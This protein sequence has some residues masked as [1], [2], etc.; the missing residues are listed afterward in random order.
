M[1]RRRQPICQDSCVLRSFEP[2]I[3]ETAPLPGAVVERVHRDLT[4]VHHFLGDT[5]H[6]VR[7]IRSD[8]LPVTRVLDVGCGHGGVLEEVRQRLRVD[9]VGVDLHPPERSSVPIV[10]A[11]GVRDCL[12][13]ADVAYSICVAHHLTEGEVA[14]LICNVGRSC[15]RFILL[16][17]VRHW[18]P[19]ALFRAFVAPLLSHVAATDGIVS[20]RRAYTPEEFRAIAASTGVRFRHSV[21]PFYTRQILDIEY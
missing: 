3:L 12:P 14:A 8:P 11:D 7:A 5:R 2:E 15:R 4:K 6:V 18:L 20:V 13:K 10:R 19:L 21:A 16:D 9:V 17:L 1:L